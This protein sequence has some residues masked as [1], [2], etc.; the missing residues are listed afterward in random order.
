MKKSLLVLLSAVVISIQSCKNNTSDTILYSYENGVFTINEGP[1]QNGSGEISFYD[2][3]T[4][5]QTKDLYF[6]N[7][8]SHLGNVVQSF[9]AEKAVGYVVV[10]NAD[11]IVL[12]DMV[13]FKY[14][15]T[16]A[17]L[18]L[19]RQMKRVTANKAYITQ[20]GDSIGSVKVYDYKTN[21]ITKTIYLGKG[22]ENML[23][24]GNRIYV[25]CNGAFGNDNK[26]GIIDIEKDS[27]LSLV[28]IGPN[29]DGIVAD[30]TNNIWIL[31]AGQYISTFNNLDANGR[32]LRYNTLLN[33][34][35]IDV[36]MPSIYSQPRNLQIN[37]EKNILYYNYDGAVYAKSINGATIGTPLING[38]FYG[39]GVEPV[40]N[41]IYCADA[42]NFVSDGQVK[43]YS[44][45]GVLQDSFQVGVAPNGFVFRQP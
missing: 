11:K 40:T 1:F 38:Y 34:I 43:R 19:P 29:P 12:V 22:A 41:K 4:F 18:R 24:L 16:I 14:Q 21:Q 42:R 3:N 26:L 39:L 8:A 44:N 5:I 23:L 36:M 32:L 27:L 31:C 17:G 28:S 9:N 10:N 7:N 33:S 45:T 30:A 35:D 37:T 13:N 15:A 2:K 6:K 20:W 25:T